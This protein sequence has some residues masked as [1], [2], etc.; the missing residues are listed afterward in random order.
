[1]PT[2]K[3]LT[4]TCLL[5]S[6]CDGNLHGYHGEAP[7]VPEC[8]DAVV[9]IALDA[10]GSVRLP[11][12]VKSVDFASKAGTALLSLNPN[13]RVGVIDFSNDAK[14][15]IPLTDNKEDFLKGIGNLKNGYQNGITRTEQ[16]LEKALEVFNRNKTNSFAKK[17]LVVVTDGRTTPLN[18]AQGDTLL[19]EPVNKL[20]ESG[21]S[22]VAIGVFARA[23]DIELNLI[24]SEQVFRVDNYDQ[25]LG[26]VQ[27]ISQVACRSGAGKLSL[28]P[29]SLQSILRW[30]GNFRYWEVGNL[31]F[32]STALRRFYTYWSVHSFES[33]RCAAQSTLSEYAY[34]RVT[35][36]R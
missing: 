26:K 30:K 12:W 13:N 25:L 4:K 17:L 5:C 16:A 23:N 20:R 24:S 21:V 2:Q 18:G 27:K 31:I 9:L 22:T 1:M 28:P 29:N 6:F 35:R 34:D 7:A 3:W 8:P 15:T 33:M 10:S 19:M 14:E 36:T 11:N 32:R